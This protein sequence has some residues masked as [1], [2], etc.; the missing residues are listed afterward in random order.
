MDFGRNRT[1]K[2]DESHQPNEGNVKWNKCAKK[3]SLQ[4]NYKLLNMIKQNRLYLAVS[5][6]KVAQSPAAAESIKQRQQSRAGYRKKESVWETL[7]RWQGI[8]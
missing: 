2:N 3:K 1:N 4:K 5:S 8:R 6:N 7:E